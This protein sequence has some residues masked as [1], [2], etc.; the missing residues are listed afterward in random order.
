MTAAQ[1]AALIR[2][3]QMS[4]EELARSCLARVA[5]RDA[6]V[7]AWLWLDP[8][9]V[10]RRAREL[11][12][13]PP[14]GPLHG[15]P[16]GVKDV[17][18]TA[19]YP[20]TQNSPIYDGAK[21]G[22]DAACV[23]VVRGNGALIMGK[24]DTVE[25]ASGGRKAVTRNPY[26]PAHTPGGSSSGSGAAV[27]DFQ[28]P[29]AFGTQTGGSHIR[30]ASFNGIYALKP[31]W[32]AVSREGARMSSMTLDTVGWYGRSVDDLSL[33]AGAFRIA[34]HPHPIDVRGLKV[35]VCRSPVWN[36]IEPGGALALDTAAK[37]LADAGAVVMDLELP[38]PFS[39]LHDAHTAIVNREGGGSFLPEYV[40]ARAM[41]APDLRAKVEN[42]MQ[43]T[44][45][46][47]LAA[48]A[49]A[50]RCRPLLD[51]LFG[52][53]LDV[54]L[55]PSAPGEAPVGLHTTGDAVFNRMWTLLHGPNI[56]I[57]C[58]FGPAGLPVGVTLVGPRLSDSR[59]LAIAKACAPAIDAEPGAGL[60]RLWDGAA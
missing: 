49:L 43:I 42:A 10:V 36:A 45:E 27:G 41:L 7:K 47:L 19:D 14:Q 20:T 40:N 60:R 52:P 44:D 59:L 35:G 48:Y 9:H 58:C 55:T 22:R 50:D 31:T 39:R 21:I 13:L 54:I 8:D 24:T 38:E 5:A 29:C 1:A 37:R 17:I 23:A 28:V 4:C 25:F 26:N 15:I 56:G 51:G 30:P 57:P 6:A 12:K 11:D 33:V 18:D 46:R 32:G 2:S 53:D 34:E 3:K 16:F